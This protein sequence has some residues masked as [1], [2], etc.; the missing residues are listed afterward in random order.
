M[1][2]AEVYNSL[3]LYQL[4]INY[5]EHAI[6]AYIKI[7]GNNNMYISNIFDKI[8]DLYQN[9]NEC[10]L[11]IQYYQISLNILRCNYNNDQS[12]SEIASISKKLQIIFENLKKESTH[13]K[14]SFENKGE[15]KM[16]IIRF[17]RKYSL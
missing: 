5:Y 7:Y 16:P 10:E 4:A 2:L 1:K 11:A 14:S 17:C 9:N 12:T 3:S 13:L 6:K 8:A 15:S